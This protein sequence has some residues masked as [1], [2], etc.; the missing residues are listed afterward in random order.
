[1]EREEFLRLLWSEVIGS[2]MHGHWI[3]NSLN[4]IDKHPDAPE[5]ELGRT[6]R[7]LLDAGVAREDLCR[8]VR[9]MASDAVFATLYL[10]EEPGIS[11]VT[12]D[13]L[14]GLSEELLTADPSGKDGLPSRD[15]CRQ[16]S[17]V[18]KAVNKLKKGT[19]PKCCKLRPVN[20]LN[21]L[22]E[23]DPRF[24]KR[25]VNPGMGFW[26]FDTAW[27]TIQGYEVTNQLRKGQ[28]QGTNKVDIRSQ[29]RFV[30][31]AFGLAA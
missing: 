7:R 30:E 4:V 15:Q 31:R 14:C 13:N 2:S 21:N 17:L 18:P 19:L 16:E 6:L 24:I 27:R 28:G 12:N 23:Q 20:Y 10:L 1:M 3:E 8:I 5:A 9:Y 25:R 26:S 29:I 11:G 22:V